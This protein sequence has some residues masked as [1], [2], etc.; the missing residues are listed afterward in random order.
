MPDVFGVEGGGITPKG[1]KMPKWKD[2]QRRDLSAGEGK[3]HRWFQYDNES[4]AIMVNLPPRF[5]PYKRELEEEILD[6]FYGA[7]PVGDTAESINDFIKRWCER[8]EDEHPELK[9]INEV[10]LDDDGNP[11]PGY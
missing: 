5:A 8:M 4:G 1:Y 2:L 6:F 3:K 7:S 11:R 10:E 9:E